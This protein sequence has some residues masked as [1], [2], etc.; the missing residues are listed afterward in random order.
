[1]PSLLRF[2]LLCRLWACALRL[3]RPQRGQLRAWLGLSALALALS[4]SLLARAEGISLGHFEATTS[5]EGLQLSFAAKFELSRAV[6]DALQKGLPLIFVAEARV[7]QS[8]WYWADKSVATATR[9]WRL[10]YQPLTRQY[11]VTFAGVS[12]SHEHLA[13]ALATLSSASRW[14]LADRTQLDGGGHYLEFS[15]RLDTAQLPRLLKIG[16]AGQSEWQLS[17]ERT[18]RIK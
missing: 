16:V 17:V 3:P 9:S 8:R 4:H 18:Q 15:Y 12:Q 5:E 2:C 11:R 6:D 13:D 7:Y 10:A 14:K 1:V